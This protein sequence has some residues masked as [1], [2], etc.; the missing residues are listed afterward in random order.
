MRARLATL[1]I[2]GGLTLG[3][4]AYGDLGL[5]AGYGSPYYGYGYG[6][7]YGGYGY[8]SPYYGGGY[9]LG[10][11][12]GYG[13]GS[14][15]YGGYYGSPYYGWY[16]DYYY[17]GTGYYVYDRDRN[18]RVMTDA[19]RQYWRQRV[20]QAV[21]NNIR[22]KDGVSTTGTTTVR[23]QS[24]RP[25]WSGFNTRRDTAAASRQTARTERQTIRTERQAARDER[26]AN[27]RND[28]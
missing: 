6:S 4:C 22:E 7:P 21:A 28:D 9:G 18:R 14:P 20:A 23:T 24:V 10:Y 19:E 26:R 13:Y 3:G 25:N 2:A 1:L 27:R 17:P 5:G 8:G 15:Y 12:L 16:N 11:S